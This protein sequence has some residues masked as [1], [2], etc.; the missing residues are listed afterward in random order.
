MLHL[1]RYNL[2]HIT[3]AAFEFVLNMSMR[4]DICA[5]LRAYEELESDGG[6][7]LYSAQHPKTPTHL[8]EYL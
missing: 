3:V 8:K 1:L 5:H 6:L 4:Q 7:E 2:L